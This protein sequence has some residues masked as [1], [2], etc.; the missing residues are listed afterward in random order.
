MHLNG[1]IT[2]LVALFAIVSPITSI[3]VFL[4]LTSGTTAKRRRLTAVQT[5]IVSGLTLL[6]AYFVGEIILKLSSIQMEAS[7]IA[8]ALVIGSIGWSMVI[9]KKNSIVQ[10]DATGAMV[11]PSLSQCWQALE[12]SPQ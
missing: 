9:G 3:P 8:G 5:A 2:T 12:Q 1:D 6:I 4:S 7:R 11:V 10:A